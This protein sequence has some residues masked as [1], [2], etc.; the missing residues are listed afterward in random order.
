MRGNKQRFNTY[1]ER[2]IESNEED[3]NE[4]ES[5]ISSESLLTEESEKDSGDNETDEKDVTE[6][7]NVNEGLIDIGVELESIRP[8]ENREESMTNTVD[9]STSTNAITLKTI[10]PDPFRRETIKTRIFI[11]QIDNKITNTTET[12]E[13]KKI[14][15]IMSLLRKVTTE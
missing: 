14:C 11:L 4:E 12:F 6:Q 1:R 13:R 2:T 9:M 3:F 15:Y 8:T 7:Q 5:N 10:H